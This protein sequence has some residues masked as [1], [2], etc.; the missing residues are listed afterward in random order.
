MGGGVV[1]SGHGTHRHDPV[2]FKN[3]LCRVLVSNVFGF[4]KISRNSTM[5]LVDGASSP[6]L[7]SRVLVS[8][9]DHA[10]GHELA[11]RN[12]PKQKEKVLC[13]LV[14]KRLWPFRCLVDFLCI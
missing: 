7:R 8:I 4:S 10:G 12:Q 3:H 5:E 1:L 11:N 9:K 14:R 6:G 2:V 13:F